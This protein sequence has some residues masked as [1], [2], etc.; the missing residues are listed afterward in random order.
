MKPSEYIRRNVWATFQDD[1]IGPM[2][3]RYFGEQNLMWASDFP[4]TDSTW[5][6]SRK[7]IEQDFQ[8][9]PVDVKSKIIFGNAA[10]LY[11][12]ELN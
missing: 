7:V 11:N 6:N 10:K 5:P 2:L 1:M 9:V 8:D 12:I 4:H 3:Y